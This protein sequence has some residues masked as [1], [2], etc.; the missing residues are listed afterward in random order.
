MP[1]KL[2]PPRQGK[3]PYYSVRGTYLRVYVDR[4]TGTADR[5]AADRTRRRWIA[6]IECGEYID[7]HAV[8]PT[9]ESVPP[10]VSLQSPRAT[11]F[12]AAAI[13]YM[14]AGGD[15]KRLGPIIK[16][17]SAAS[18]RDLPLDRIDQLAID[19]A[20]DDLYP[21]A[22]PQT[23]N[24][25]FYTPVAAVLHRAGLERRIKRP[26]GW[27]GT[28]ST[29]WLEPQQAFRLFAEADAIDRE[30]GLL[31]RFLIYTGLRLG[32]ALNAR[33]RDLHLDERTL[34]V[35]DTKTG[36]PRPVYIP[37]VIMDALMAQTPRLARPKAAKGR[38]LKNGLAGRSQADAGKPFLERGPDAKLFRF[39]AS[40][41]LRGM[42]AQALK[43]ARLSFPRRQGGFHLF[44]HTYGTWMHHYGQLDTFGLVR[45]NRWKHPDSADR[46]RHTKV[47]EEARRA[48]LLPVEREAKRP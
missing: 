20:A 42:L 1:L 24:R 16:H 44:C 26:I 32:E 18:I 11:T 38:R 19:N 6:E 43:R 28:Q 45:T 8:E 40:G 39:H 34:Y 21:R 10:T 36:T 9:A 22:T 47:S 35:P 4:S 48:D 46:Y 37:P 3:T 7:P 33:L 23:K 14:R 12:L 31:V 13:A 29:A 5:K 41:R 15:R 27:K 30:F 25:E 17:S 2:K